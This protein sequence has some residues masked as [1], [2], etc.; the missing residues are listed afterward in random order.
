MMDAQP[1]VPERRALGVETPINGPVG[2]VIAVR[3]AIV[4]IKF[5]SDVPLPPIYD[6]IETQTADGE[7]V[8]LEVAEHMEGNLAK[9]IAMTSTIGLQRNARAVAL[10]APLMVPVGPQMFS[11]LTNVM[12][13]PI[14]RK[15]E[16]RAALRRPIR[17]KW[18]ALTLDPDDFA[19][20][21]YEILETGVKIID[22]LYPLL[23]GS[24]SGFLGGAGLGKS[25][26][27]L[28]LIHNIV[29][30]H[31]GACVFIGAGERIR[32]GNELY[33]ELERTNLL[34]KVIMIFGQMNELPGARSRVVLSGITMAEHLQEQGQDVLLFIDNVYRFC[35]AGSELSTLMGRIPSE[36]GYQPTLFSEM[37]EF[38]ERIRSRKGG[39]ITAIEAV[40]MP[41]DDPTDPAVVCIFSYLD[42]NMVLSRERVQAG[43]YPAI[44][45]LVSSSGH[46]DPDIVGERHFGIATEALRAINK[47]EDLKRIV[48]VIGVDELSVADRTIYERA[49]KLQNFLTQPFFV[50]EAYTGKKGEYVP[51]VD[52]L[53][54]CEKILSG[55]LDNQP[56]ESLYMIGAIRTAKK[57]VQ[58]PRR[59]GDLLVEQKQITS[60]QL[61][62]ALARQ[63][64]TQEPLGEVLVQMGSIKEET[65]VKFLS[66]QLRRQE[67]KP[68]RRLGDI[69]IESKLITPEQLERA[70]ERQ[71][72]TGGLLGSVL[73]HMGFIK[74]TELV[75]ALSDQLR[76][77]GAKPG[78]ETRRLG[79]LLVEAKQITAEQLKQALARQK[80]RGEQLGEALIKMGAIKEETLVK[81]LSEQLR[82]QER[83]V[84]RLGDILI[85][86][87]LATPEQID[88]A[89]A[90][91]KASGQPLGTLLVETKIIT[92]QQ[93]MRVLSEQIERIALEMEE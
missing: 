33:F 34:D 28:E 80:A 27:T 58:A 20:E 91:Q 22:L 18:A 74:G 84:K 93:L 81:F 69:L 23:K 68:V 9:C 87:K 40:F 59:L 44:D 8:P 70:I 57:S 42:S 35:Q 39:S 51:L 46:L 82:R 83:P 73:I 11:R 41:G 5:E 55:E 16:I 2:R 56:E 75:R 63:K 72:A 60:E 90:R 29:E 85:E 32:E 10:G 52:T 37:A 49:R 15:G 76:E 13:D 24:K 31:Q 6:M 1:G 79:D 65:L 78:Q 53:T 61:E 21:G 14:D 47:Y 3:G 30:R 64:A 38:Q 88:L 45:P 26:L 48:T 17:K 7:K 89:L 4:D 86:S 67:G 92:Q 12:G 66:E 36:T 77:E 19:R 54:G 43:L 25:I 71:K 50:G 62:E